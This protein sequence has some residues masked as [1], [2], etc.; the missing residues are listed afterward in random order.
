M[1]INLF[2]E[3]YPVKVNV[4]FNSTIKPFSVMLG[5]TAG[6]LDTANN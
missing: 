3:V 2:V 5:D 4:H 6:K 1:F